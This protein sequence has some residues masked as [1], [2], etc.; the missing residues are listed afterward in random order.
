[1]TK[2][3]PMRVTLNGQAVDIDVTISHPANDL[4][5]LIDRKAAKGWRVLSISWPPSGYQHRITSVAM[6]SLE[7]QTRDVVSVWWVRPAAGDAA[8]SD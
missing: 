6:P 2:Q 7:R 5:T 1:M 8:T 3:W 4:Q